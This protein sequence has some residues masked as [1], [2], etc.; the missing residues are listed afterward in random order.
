MDE[1]DFEYADEL[2]AMEDVD[3]PGYQ[4]PAS[5]RSLHF[6][7]P[8]GKSS[9]SKANEV[10]NN[11]FNTSSEL[12]PMESPV[13]AKNE[14]CT[15]RGE[16][17]HNKRRHISQSDE[18]IEVIAV[19]NKDDSED[20]M[21]ET[22]NTSPDPVPQVKRPRL[23]KPE[24]VKETIPDVITEMI[25]Q[26]R[27]QRQ[28][29]HQTETHTEYQ[30]RIFE[31][32]DFERKR[33]T[34]SVPNTNFMSVTGTDGTRV[35]MRLKNDKQLQ[36]ESLKVAENAK[37]LHLLGMPFSVLMEK[38]E[39]EHTASVL[40]EA[41]RISQSI[42][43]GLQECETL[44]TEAAA[45]E[46]TNDDGNKEN[47][48]A[49]GTA[50]E[51]EGNL[52]VDK[53]A[54]RG[55]T[56]LLSDETINR[57]VLSWLKQWDYV[58]FGKEVKQ[59]KKRDVDPK[60]TGFKK[61]IPQINLELDKLNRP[62]QKIALLSGPPGLGKTTLSHVIA[63]HAGYNVVEMNASDDRSMEV[64]KTKLESAILMK[65]VMESDPRPNCLIIDEIDGAPQASINILLNMLKEGQTGKKKEKCLLYRPIIC[66]CNDLYVPA[67][68]QLR[69]SALV[70]TF[71]PTE[72]AR[73]ASRLYSVAKLEHV[74]AEM[75]ALVALCEKT[76][77]D[78]RSCLNTLQ[79][80][81]H[82]QKEFNLR[83][84]Q[85]LNVGQKDVQKSLFSVWYDIFRMPQA[86]KSKYL[87]VQ[88]LQT[89]QSNN[90][91]NTTP[92]A[93]F[94]HILSITQAA[95][96]FEKIMHGLFQNYLEV[97]FKDPGMERINMA[98]HWLGFVDELTNYINKQQDYTLMTYQSYLT[99]IY[100]FL[101]AS[102][103]HP[104]ITYPRQNIEMNAKKTRTENLVTS[105][106]TD[107][108]PSVRKYQNIENVILEV[109]PP[110]M[111]IM[112]PSLRP[113][114]TQLYSNREKE[115][116]KQLIRNMIAYNMTY[117]QEK[118]PE[119]QYSYILDPNVEE[120]VNF[121]GLKQHKQLT[122][123]AK[124]LIAREIEIEKMRMAERSMY[125][126]MS[127][128]VGSHVIPNHKQTLAPR[129]IAEQSG[130]E[131]DFFGR[132][133]QK[134]AVPN[135]Q[136][137]VEEKKDT[138]TKEIWFHFKEGFS[139]AVRRNVKIQDLL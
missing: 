37:S 53:Y 134:K 88:D 106:F 85:S 124:Q 44:E 102:N 39:E 94:H 111:I 42:N 30:S 51:T 114:N 47:Q 139:N 96:E 130:P 5:K 68:R 20:E 79:F 86:K 50:T 34:F 82:Q 90:Q 10:L 2:E 6:S 32:Y 14:P 67:L 38:I 28:G 74:K 13:S 138:F 60:Q 104:K 84:V 27:R 33:V 29:Q 93:R 103:T 105:M 123:A 101:F 9:S 128:D 92:S 66:I 43:I 64:F 89:M 61:K 135:E 127:G 19:N 110:L 100:H 45:L 87:T 36:F 3:L 57:T 109:L 46:P 108:H 113:V 7:T 15:S 107:M 55:Y 23:T 91:P 40:A 126:N 31:E 52:W 78:I 83:L 4:P 73:L 58:V 1:F 118:L 80:I 77:N 122:Y 115:G 26:T 133:I 22:I 59:P 121:P 17:D 62:I 131:R 112:Q 56:E 136:K 76:D 11:S 71:P 63:K 18:D 69:Q 81:H 24:K 75:N 137:A 70:F 54:P 120:V 49:G 95:G 41:E 97:K 129:P 72:P 119:G 98:L 48:C 125:S 116:L 132:V 8:S 21:L 99:V 25:L 117:R 65:S 12:L 16:I 35:Y